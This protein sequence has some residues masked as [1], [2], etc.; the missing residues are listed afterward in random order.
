MNIKKLPYGDSDFGKII[1]SNMYYVDKTKYIHELESLPNYIFLIRPR[2]F[3]KSLWINLLQYYYDSNRKDQF[4]T[5]FKD[6]FIGQNPTPNKNRYMTLAFNFAMV[7]PKFDR[8]QEEF[9]SYVSSI[10]KDFLMRYQNSFEKSFIAE[11]QSYERVN[12]KLQEL[13]LYCARNQLKVYMFIDEYDNFTNTIL[14]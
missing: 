12:K 2:R 8:V 10:I 11:L 6:T 7:D 14:T 9:Q 5:L 13:F 3:G 1:K 4:D